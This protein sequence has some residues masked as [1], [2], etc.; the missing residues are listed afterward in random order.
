MILVSFLIT[1]EQRRQFNLLREK[2]IVSESTLLREAIAEY[3]ERRKDEIEVFERESVRYR[4]EK[5]EK[6]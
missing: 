6:A 2:R 5:E 3:L 4:L 1:Q